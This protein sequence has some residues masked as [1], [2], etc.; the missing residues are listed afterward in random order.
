MQET[1]QEERCPSQ[2]E[3]GHVYERHEM[4][5]RSAQIF[6]DALARSLAPACMQRIRKWSFKSVVMRVNSNFPND[7]ILLN[8]AY[9]GRKE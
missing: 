2:R 8:A 1:H 9:E 7:S 6:M 4:R 3:E 5:E